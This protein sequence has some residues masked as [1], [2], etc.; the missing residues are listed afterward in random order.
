M[1]LTSHASQQPL[2]E[3][4]VAC[5]T[6]QRS[7]PPERLATGMGH[8]RDAQCFGCHE[9]FNEIGKKFVLGV[10]D[11]RYYSLPIRDER[12]ASL[13]K[14]PLPYG[15]APQDLNWNKYERNR[16]LDFL[17][18]P[19]GNP[20]KMPAFPALAASEL[21]FIPSAP[22]VT[23][24]DASR[25]EQLYAQRC[26][27]CHAHTEPASGRSALM[28]SVFSSAWIQRYANGQIKGLERKMPPLKISQRDAD[29]LF[30]YFGRVRQEA[31]HS[32]NLQLENLSPP[33]GPSSVETRIVNYVENRFFRDGGCVHCHGIEG[34][35][36]DQ[37]DTSMV[38]LK[39]WFAKHDP[40]DLWR[41]LETRAYEEKAGLGAAKPGM[42]MTGPALPAEM[43]TLILKWIRA[44]C[45]LSSGERICPPA[46]A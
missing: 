25:G 20:S 42:P 28:L 23:G 35:A 34:R 17:K 12:L 21:A 1:A 40:M 32:L 27:A 29:D 38:G 22:A 16:L 3:D 7:V 9:E 30:L 45:P 6:S 43:R 44:E 4:C 15:R 37:L 31:E 26:A 19:H 2:P 8:W 10:K 36:R 11:R 13:I 41:R 14:R 5:H 33:Q 24:A 18:R 46:S 39:T